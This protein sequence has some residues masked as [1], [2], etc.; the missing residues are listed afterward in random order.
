M[1][2]IPYLGFNG[3]CEAAFKFY[4]QCLGGKIVAMMT[5]G[6]MPASEQTAPEQRGRIMH[7]RLQ[8]GDAVLM[9]GDRPQ[10]HHEASQG[11]CVSIQIDDPARAER[12]FNA[13]ADGGQVQMPFG[14]TFWAVRFGMLID[15][16]GTPWMINCEKAA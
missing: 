9:G 1:Q 6:D 7:A 12:I 15:R 4:E 8:A 3:Q 2:L 10:E 14:E 5:Y 11:F 13:L 16:F